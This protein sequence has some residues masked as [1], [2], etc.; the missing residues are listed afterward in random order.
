[1]PSKGARR[2]GPLVEQIIEYRVE[3]SIRR[4][5]GLQQILIGLYKVDRLDRCFGIRICRQQHPARFRKFANGG[6]KKFDPAHVGHPMIGHQESD[7]FRTPGKPLQDIERRGAR[8]GGEHAVAAA[9]LL[10]QIAFNGPQDVRIVID[11]KH[12]RS[13]HDPSADPID[14]HDPIAGTR[15]MMG[16]AAKNR[17]PL[18]H[19]TISQAVSFVENHGYA[20]LFV[21]VLVEQSAIPLPSIPLLLAAGALIRSG[22]LYGSLAIACCMAAALIADTV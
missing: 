8:V 18:Q 4:I 11:S 3:V 17:V 22:R 19:L 14:D 5:P 20:L 21:W 1:M 12:D 6:G 10:S 9:V 15:D 7:R 2:S 16:L 13:R